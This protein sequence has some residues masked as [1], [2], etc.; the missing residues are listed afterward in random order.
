M[1]DN[2]LV[3]RAGVDRRPSAGGRLAAATGSQRRHQ[4]RRGPARGHPPH[5]RS[6]SWT[7]PLRAK[8]AAVLD[9][10]TLYRRMPL[11]DLVPCDPDL[12]LFVVRHPDVIVNIWEVL[13]VAQL[14]LRQT[15]PDEFRADEQEGTSAKLQFLYH[16]RDTH[17]IYGEWQYTGTMLPRTVKGRCLAMFASDLR[18]QRWTAVAT[19]PIAWTPL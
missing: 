4:Q 12:Y 13:G 16:T 10:V 3:D 14:Q 11:S 19:S 9:N 2:L 17:V 15:G 5:C 8:V 18:P 6:R 1:G 7:R